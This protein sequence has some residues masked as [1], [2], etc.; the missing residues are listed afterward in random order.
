MLPKTGLSSYEISDL[1]DDKSTD[2]VL[3]GSHIC[4]KKLKIRNDFDAAIFSIGK[5]IPQQDTPLC[6]ARTKSLLEEQG[7]KGI[8]F[9]EVEDFQWPNPGPS[10]STSDLLS[11]LTGEQRSNPML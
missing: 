4:I 10:N 7:I 11:L 9:T 8:E 3:S 6:S 1:S 5:I 2:F